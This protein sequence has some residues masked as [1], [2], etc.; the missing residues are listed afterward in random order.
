MDFVL[1]LQ[2]NFW[3]DATN[4]DPNTIAD[5]RSGGTPHT[6]TNADPKM[7]VDIQTALS[8]L[9]AKASQLIGNFTTNLAESWMHICTK[10]DGGKV[11]NRSQRVSFQHRCTGAGL[12]LNIGPMWGPVSWKSLTGSNPSETFVAAA[13]ENEKKVLKDRKRKSSEEAKKNRKK[14]KYAKSKDD[15]QSAKLAY[16]RHDG[17][18]QPD[19]VMDDIPSEHLQRLKTEYYHAHVVVDEKTAHEI[20]QST[21]EQSRATSSTGTGE[22]LWYAER[23]KRITA[24]KVGGIA[25]MRKTTKRA[26]KVKQ[27]LYSKFQGNRHIAYGLENEDTARQAYTSYMHSS[28]HSGLSTSNVGLVVSTKNPWLAASPDDRIYDPQTSPPHGL[29]EYK[30]PSSARDM[31]IGEACTQ[32]KGFCIKKETITNPEGKKITHKHLDTNHDYYYQVQCQLYCDEKQ[33][34]DFVVKTKNDLYVER[35]YRDEA[36]WQNQLQKLEDFYF[37]ALLPEIACPRIH[38]GGIREPTD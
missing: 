31:T 25:K 20:E 10:F 33:W 26:N 29:A 9:V 24:S 36:W 30:N 34:C 4:D 16:S 6:Y 1:S 38:S 13:T 11:I 8:R 28:G 32:V 7:M 17:G 27:M 5:A 18:V 3:V 35:I 21:R 23:Q 2:A 12:R 19:D 15:S 37:N 22:Q 14:R